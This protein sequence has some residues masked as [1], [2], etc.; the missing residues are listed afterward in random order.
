M[1]LLKNVPAFGD[2]LNRS[3]DFDPAFPGGE[4]HPKSILN[5]AQ[6]QRICSGRAPGLARAFSKFRVSL[7]I[8]AITADSQ[9]R[10]LARLVKSDCQGPGG[11]V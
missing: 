6:I 10:E 8:G 4:L 3:I 1:Q 5:P 11:S 2:P 9:R 7:V